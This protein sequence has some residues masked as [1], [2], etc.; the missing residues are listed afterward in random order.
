M[1]R[2]LLFLSLV[3]AA[4]YTLLIVTQDALPGGKADHT[5]A[6]QIQPNHQVVEHLS[7]WGTYLP[8][9]SLTQNPQTPLATSQQAAPLPPQQ[10]ES[11]SQNSERKP[12]ADY[13]FAASEDKA[14][15]SQSDGAEQE[16]VER[17]KVVLA[18]EMHSQASVSSP[19][20]RFYR[21]GT[22][23]QVVGRGDGGWFQVSDP[24]TQERGWVFEKYLSSIDGSSPTR[25]AMESTTEPQ[26]AKPALP[27]SK[28]WSRSARPAVRHA[29]VVAK[30]D[31]WSGQWAR[32]GDRRRGFGLFM[33]AP[34]ARF[35]AQDR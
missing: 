30:S 19:I 26:P 2:V 7:S 33:F 20:V 18:A 17:T 24:A 23:L 28:K 10:S 29:V 35:E 16:P 25:A 15:A 14:P 21:P 11:P 13:Q 1:T 9:R 31:P 6:G 12:G 22:E 4:V 5:F 3:G 27:K 32:R 8:S 34:F